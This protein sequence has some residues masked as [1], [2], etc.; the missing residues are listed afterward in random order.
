ML[1]LTEIPPA[2]GLGSTSAERRRTRQ[3]LRTTRRRKCR[4]CESAFLKS[5]LPPSQAL[6]GPLRWKKPSPDKRS[7]LFARVA[8]QT[9]NGA[10]KGRRFNRIPRKRPLFGKSGAKTSFEFGPVPV[11]AAQAQINK[12][13]LLLFV[14]K[15]QA[16]PRFLTLQPT[17]AWRW[18]CAG[19]PAPA[20]RGLPPPNAAG[21][22]RSRYRP[23]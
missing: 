1:H 22:S 13:F 3:N 8:L 12:V 18:R 19:H 11:S 21:S 15:K 2:R 10:P 7:W 17:R 6:H 9:R 23:G 14:H 16:F 5:G 4:H 20:G